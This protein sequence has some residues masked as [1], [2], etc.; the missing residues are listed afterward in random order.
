MKFLLVKD[1]GIIYLKCTLEI[2]A[3]NDIISELNKV[4]RK[5]C[6]ASFNREAMNKKRFHN[7]MQVKNK[8]TDVEIKEQTLGC[9]YYIILPGFQKGT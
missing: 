1:K 4:N 6:H 3:E 5:I 2:K 9:T 8:T 7:T